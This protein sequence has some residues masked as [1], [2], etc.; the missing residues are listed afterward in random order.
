MRTLVTCSLLA[1]VVFLLVWTAGCNPEPASFLTES[2][3]TEENQQRLI[4]S[5]QP[6]ELQTS[7]ER[8]NI[9]RR[10]ERINKE[11]MVSYIY[12]IS[13]GRVMAYYTVSGKVSSLNSYM[14]PMEQLV[15]TNNPNTTWFAVESPDQDGS[16]GKN[17]DGVFFFSTEGNY[18]EWRGEYLWSDQPLKLSQPV[19]LIQ[20][21]G[22]K[23]N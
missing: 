8:I 6:P 22:E 12:L 14:T 13:Y 11:N 19:E 4:N 18:V 2:K 16:Y 10:L 20:V 15:R 1:A 5:V 9:K 3:K 17:V 7:L 21:V 23:P